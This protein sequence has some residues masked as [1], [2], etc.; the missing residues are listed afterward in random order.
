MLTA[1]ADVGVTGLGRSMLGLGLD[2]GWGLGAEEP[3][4]DRLNIA[5]NRESPKLANH[6]K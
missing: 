6:F 5:K 1:V 3:L 2:G 4:K